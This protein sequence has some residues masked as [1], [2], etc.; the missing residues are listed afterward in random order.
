MS[1]IPGIPGASEPSFRTRDRRWM[2]LDTMVLETC[3][4]LAQD[5]DEVSPLVVKVTVQ[6]ARRLVVLHDDLGGPDLIEQ[7]RLGLH[8]RHVLISGVLVTRILKSYAAVFLELDI[9]EVS[10]ML[11]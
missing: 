10:E 2:D 8:A 9:L 5:G 3:M 11:P 4:H 6:V 1:R 7:V